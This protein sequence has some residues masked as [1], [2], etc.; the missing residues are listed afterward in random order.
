MTNILIGAGRLAE[1]SDSD[2]PAYFTA[3]QAHAW[4]CGYNAAV[5]ELDEAM[6]TFEDVASSLPDGYQIRHDLQGFYICSAAEAEHE[7]AGN[8]SAGFDG[9]P[10]FATIADAEATFRAIRDTRKGRMG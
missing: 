7:D 9:R 10:H 4:S 1:K 3:E 2:A 5:A 6:G 8:A